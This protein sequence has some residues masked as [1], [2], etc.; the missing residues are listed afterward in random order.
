[1]PDVVLCDIGLPGLN[2][3][4]VAGTLKAD[5]ATAGVRLVA[6]TGYADC[7]AVEMAHRCGFERLLAKPADPEVLRR[8]LT[9][10]AGGRTANGLVGAP[11]FSQMANDPVL[12]HSE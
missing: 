2:G 5:P 6:I 10:P 3:F 7:Q 12:V 1:M 8:V 11:A 4:E 9:Q